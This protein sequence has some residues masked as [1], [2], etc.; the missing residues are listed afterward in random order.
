MKVKHLLVEE[1]CAGGP[2]PTTMP[3]EVAASASASATEGAADSPV[4]L[5]L[6]DRKRMCRAETASV[7]DPE[8]SPIEV[9]V[10][11]DDASAN[12]KEASII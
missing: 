2:S 7:A 3:A 5:E 9:L 6:P 10:Q 12:Q 1:H 4:Y 11:Q 8:E